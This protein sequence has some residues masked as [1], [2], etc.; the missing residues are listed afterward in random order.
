[1]HVRI[2]Q[3]DIAQGFADALVNAAGTDLRMAPGVA[4]ALRRVGAEALDGAAVATGSIE[5]GGVAV[6][7][8]SDIDAD[9]A[10]RTAAMPHDGD[11]PATAEYETVRGG[12][13]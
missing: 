6:T 10:I 7:D 9:H 1:M 11:G 4:G 13:Q 3:G 8:A 12:G 5:P 2:I